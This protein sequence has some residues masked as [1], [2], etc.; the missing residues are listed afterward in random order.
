MAELV[1]HLII[2][3]GGMLLFLTCDNLAGRTLAM[4]V[5]AC[6]CVGVGTN[7]HTS[8]HYAASNKRWV[9]ELLTYFG[10]PLF[11]Q[12]SATY[13]RHKH[14][15]IHHAAPNVFGIDNDINYLPWFALTQREIDGSSRRWQCYY[16][17]QWLVVPLAIAANGCNVLAYGWS[18]VIR[19]LGNPQ[20]RQASHW[21]DLWML[22]LHWVVWV[23]IPLAFFPATDVMTFYVLRL[24]VLGYAFFFILAPAHFPAEAVCTEAS[25]RRTDFILRQTA[26]TVNFHA[27]CIGRFL[28]SGLDRQIEHHLFPGVS[29]VFYPKMSPVV[30][31]F[32]RQYGYPYRTLGWGEAIWKSFVVFRRPKSVAPC[33][34]GFRHRPGAS[35]IYRP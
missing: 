9:N 20:Q 3:C 13:W 7:T 24:G 12:L 29:H 34:Q 25:K 35:E 22:L 27:G 5:S 23:G 4:L 28:C 6:G 32:C 1:C 31:E 16:R 14:V 8:S 30:K 11:L 18:H 21:I 10:H 26:T 2:A 33:L 19:M 15:V 17:V